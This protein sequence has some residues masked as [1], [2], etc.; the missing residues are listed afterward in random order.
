M[1]ENSRI[2]RGSWEKKNLS[3]FTVKGDTFMQLDAPPI[4]AFSFWL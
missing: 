4:L 1:E 2:W 3:F